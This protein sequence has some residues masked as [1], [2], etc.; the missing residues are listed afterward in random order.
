MGRRMW[1]AIKAVA[2]PHPVLL[3]HMAHAQPLISATAISGP[4]LVSTTINLWCSFILS[5]CLRS[6]PRLVKISSVWFAPHS[7]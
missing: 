4:I 5:P 2:V 1:E 3:P 7:N 6:S